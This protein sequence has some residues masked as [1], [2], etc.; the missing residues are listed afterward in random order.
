MTGFE[1]SMS[2][3]CE[4]PIKENAHLMRFLKVVQAAVQGKSTVFDFDNFALI[5]TNCLVNHIDKLKNIYILQS[6]L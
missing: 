6:P 4:E 1:S 3:F 5:E 2:I